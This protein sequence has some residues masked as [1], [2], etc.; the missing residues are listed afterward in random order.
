MEKLKTVL[1]FMLG[2]AFLGNVVAT[3]VAPRYIAWNNSAPLAKQQECDLE[4][5]VRTV[6]SE[7]ISAQLIGSGIGAVLFLVLGIL[8]VQART[9][10]QKSTPPPAAPSPP[11]PATAQG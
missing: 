4:L 1:T 6:A 10:K 9:K 3:F 7:V 5:V 8:F 11:P 2:G